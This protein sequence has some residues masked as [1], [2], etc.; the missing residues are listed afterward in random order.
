MQCF[1]D[2]SKLDRVLADPRAYTG[3]LRLQT[4][5][6]LMALTQASASACVRVCVC[7]RPMVR[8]V[9]IQPPSL[10]ATTSALSPPPYRTANPSAYPACPLFS[11]HAL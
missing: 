8:K 7:V 4:G 10:G 5:L 1:K 9:V 3:K 2:K 6:Q 11:T